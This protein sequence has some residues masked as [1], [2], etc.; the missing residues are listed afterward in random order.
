M[1]SVTVQFQ[2]MSPDKLVSD[3]TFEYVVLALTILQMFATYG[4]YPAASGIGISLFALV[5]LGLNKFVQICAFIASFNQPCHRNRLL[6][7]S[8]S[9]SG[10]SSCVQQSLSPTSSTF[11]LC[12]HPWAYWAIRLTGLPSFSALPFTFAFVV[13]VFQRSM[14]A[15]FLTC[16]TPTCNVVPQMV[17]C[18][19][20]YGTS[21]EDLRRLF[22]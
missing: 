14:V 1:A 8:H 19:L 13:S 15:I 11:P 7:G 17:V 10:A 3:T 20:Y 18:S 4:F 21:L 6:L 16:F 9:G 22:F 12:I 2:G 5:A